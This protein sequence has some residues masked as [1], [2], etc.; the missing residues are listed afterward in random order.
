MIALETART[1]GE[2]ARVATD[3]A[4]HAVVDVVRATAIAL[5]ASLE[6][7]QVVEEMRRARREIRDVHTLDSQ[8]ETPRASGA[9]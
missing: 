3:A 7:M 8:L 6:R 9:S 4:R 5:N 1:A 2:E